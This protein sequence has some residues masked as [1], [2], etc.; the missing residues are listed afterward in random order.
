M[1]ITKSSEVFL[2][3]IN[4]SI[5]KVEDFGIHSGV[6]ITLSNGMVGVGYYPAWKPI[7]LNVKSFKA[8]S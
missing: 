8:Q 7:S 4:A 2:N 1:N 6:K 5:L 3:E